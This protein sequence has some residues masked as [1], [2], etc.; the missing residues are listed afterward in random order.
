MTNK[1]KMDRRSFLRRAAVG[2][3]A[4]AAGALAAPAV[5]AQAPLVLKMQTSWPAGDIWQEMAQD[6]ATRVEE[7]SGGR[8]KIDVLPAGA[9]V[10]AFQV[11]DAVNDGVLDIAH[12]VPV[13]W[14]G[15]NKA[16][17]LFGTG[18][19]F[20]GSATTMLSWFYE[21]GGKALYDELTQDIMGLEVDGYMGF[22]MFAQPF[23]WFKGE[24]N[25]V[26]DLQGFKYRTVGLAAD[27]L[28][29]MGMSV[30]QLPGGEIVPAM[31][32]GVI[33]AFEFN[34][35]SSD[36]NFGAHDVAKN[37]YLSSYHQ[38]SESFEFL[39]NKLTM[40]DLD[41]DMRAILKYAVEAASTANTAK[42]MRRYSADLKWLQEEAGVTIHRTSTDILNGQI[43]AWDKLIPVLEEDPFMKKCLDSQRAWVEQVTYY[44]L[45]NAPDY[46]LAF[47][48]YFPGK[49]KM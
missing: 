48:H 33:D 45:M 28:Q 5:L 46:A 16:A 10:G 30:A 20:G 49:L 29:S 47:D 11:L 32:R 9:V 37:Y 38:A 40:E 7:M 21:G 26:A 3:P 4:V 6:Y 15:K 12:S 2:A 43:E 44:E 8:L 19:V 1:S 17:S 35:P 23:G 41:P 25:T 27:L 36:R 18:P 22:P 42:A 39:F 14:Y 24:V 34:N 31:E 13:Y